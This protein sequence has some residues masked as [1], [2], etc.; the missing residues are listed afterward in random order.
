MYRTMYGNMYGQCQLAC[1]A[2]TFGDDVTP[3]YNMKKR[4]HT[5]QNIPVANIMSDTMN[6]SLGSNASGSLFK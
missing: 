3:N 2:A 5:N 1:K 6:L 4:I